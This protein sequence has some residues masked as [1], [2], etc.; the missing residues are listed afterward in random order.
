MP[1]SAIGLMLIAIPG[2]AVAVA[3]MLVAANRGRSARGWFLM[4]YLTPVLSFFAVGLLDAL[5]N[6]GVA[7]RFLWFG[8]YFVP[9][10]VLW[11]LPTLRRHAARGKESGPGQRSTPKY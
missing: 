8:S 5:T 3:A 10:Y 6:W 11:R 9:L 7:L 4:G 1:D 2:F